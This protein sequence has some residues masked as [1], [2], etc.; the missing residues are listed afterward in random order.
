MIR[1][2]ITL[3]TD[4]G[5]SFYVGQ[6]KGCLARL[7]PHA[8]VIDITH[9]ITPQNI[10][11]GAIVLQDSIPHF[12]EGSIH[13]AVVDPGVGTSR[14]LVAAQIGPWILIGPDNGLLSAIASDWPVGQ[15]VKLTNS[16]LWNSTVS[17][18]FHGR[19]IMVPV[20]AT[21]AGGVSLSELGE[22]QC[23]LAPSPISPIQVL[24]KKVLGMTVSSDSF[25]NLLTNIRGRELNALGRTMSSADSVT[26]Q[27][28]DKGIE[29]RRKLP[30]IRT[31][32]ERPPGTLVAIVG[33]SDRM[34]IGVVGGN[35]KEL[36]ENERPTVQIRLATTEEDVD[37]IL[38]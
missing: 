9:A 6:M 26:I 14:A 8:Q 37:T 29:N 11:E 2:W 15:I 12:P 21:I 19:D 7:I 31:Y 38:P 28:I 16:R 17:P 35:A 27:W 25:G 30:W 3:T 33:S 4:F 36:F 10:V 32:G 5:S 18:T 23:G 24:A 1:P 13:I 34:E 20:A 22:P